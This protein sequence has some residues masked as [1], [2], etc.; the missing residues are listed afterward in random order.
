M[1]N[2][3]LLIKQGVAVESIFK[4]VRAYWKSAVIIASIDLEIFSLIKKQNTS[5]KLSQHINADN[6]SLERL[7][8]ALVNLNLLQ[9]HKKSYTNTLVSTKYLHKDGP[10]YI[11][12]IIMYH[13]SRYQV[14]GEISKSI[15][16]GKAI[17]QA[18]FLIPDQIQIDNYAKAMSARAKLEV[19][20]V[21]ERI[22]LK[23]CVNLLDL[24]GAPG[25][26]ASAFAKKYSNIKNIK[27]FD[28]PDMKNIS[29]ELLI[30]TSDVIN[31]VSGN[32]DTDA[33]GSNY[34]AV[35]MSQILDSL[36]FEN[37]RKLI[38]KVFNSLKPGGKIIIRDFILYSENT[39]PEVAIYRNL[40]VLI[41]TDKGRV[42]KKDEF[43]NLLLKV[44]FINLHF[45]ELHGL[46]DLILGEKPE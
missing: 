44:G 35:F 40:N 19:E 8:D 24:G 25:T 46:S 29:E 27:V 33:I 10:H 9:K 43:Q 2:D 37:I 1:V 31:F 45:F 21:I 15:R 26:F 36:G 30:G 3:I 28:L 17:T 7:L 11:G 41:T 39:Q 23:G 6:N 4:D 13:K 42:L 5:L 32:F 34:C 16:S 12:H 20:D 38:D 22:D 14:W 18:S